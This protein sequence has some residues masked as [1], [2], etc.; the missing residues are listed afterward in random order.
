LK[1]KITEIELNTK[2]KNIRDMNRGITEFKK[3]YQ[4][5]T[6]LV[7]DEQGDLLADPQKILFRW[8]N[9]FCQLLNVQGPGGI[10]QTEIHTAEPFVPGP[11]AAEVEVAL[12]KMK[13][14]KAPGSDQISAELVQAGGGTL[15]SE[16]HKLIML[17]WNKEELPHQWKESIVVP[18]HKKSDKTD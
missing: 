8:K 11:N 6:I 7:M 13:T 14:Y 5:K 1:G 3:G 17:I 18:I 15:H 12:R 9:Y 2:D 10:R 4:P 16:I